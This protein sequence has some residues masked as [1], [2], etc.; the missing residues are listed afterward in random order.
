MPRSELSVSLE[1][2]I[3]AASR[4]QYELLLAETERAFARIVPCDASR[5]LMHCGGA[6]REWS[7]LDGGED[8]SAVALPKE[9]L[10]WDHVRELG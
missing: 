9:S 3:A 7:A 1:P 10:V 4:G 5:A 2:I 8:R 6:W